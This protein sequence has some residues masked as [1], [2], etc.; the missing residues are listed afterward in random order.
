MP[1]PV[2]VHLNLSTD[3]VSQHCVLF[4]IGHTGR[5]IYFYEQTE[6][7]PRSTIF[8][9]NVEKNRRYHV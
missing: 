6:A 3:D 1:F 5:R 8:D 4:L 7:L 9:K 2:N